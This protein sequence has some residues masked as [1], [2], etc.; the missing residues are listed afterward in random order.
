[1]GYPFTTRP[2]QAPLAA[3]ARCRPVDPRSTQSPFPIIRPLTGGPREVAVRRQS[4]A[5]ID[6]HSHIFHLCHYCSLSSAL[7]SGRPA[8]PWF[9]AVAL[10]PPPAVVACNAWGLFRDRKHAPSK[11]PTT[12]SP[13]LR[14]ALFSCTGQIPS[15]ARGLC[16]ARGQNGPLTL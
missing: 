2:T 16:S 8:T 9:A 10:W 14:H 13:I 3:V 11:L 7:H 4:R 6:I 5:K 1:V 12:S 15:A